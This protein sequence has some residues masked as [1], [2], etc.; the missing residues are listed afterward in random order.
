VAKKPPIQLLLRDLK[1]RFPLPGHSIKFHLKEKIGAAD[2]EGTCY[3][4]YKN[5][6]RGAPYFYM[7]VKKGMS[8]SAQAGILLHEY[9]HALDIIRN[10][11][12]PPSERAH[13]RKSWGQCY[14]E[15]YRAFLRIQE[16]L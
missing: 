1:K 8:Y 10:G 3:G 5:K 13:H 7:I 16:E 11:K 2:N 6:N 15:V 9:A 12:Y 14:S 4:P